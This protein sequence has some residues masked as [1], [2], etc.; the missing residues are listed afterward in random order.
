MLLCVVIA[1]VFVGVSGCDY[2][3]EVRWLWRVAC[4]RKCVVVCVWCVAFVVCL[5]FI[6]VGGCRLFVCVVLFGGGFACGISGVIRGCLCCV[7][8]MCCGCGMFC[9]WLLFVFADV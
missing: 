7:W 4:V 3:L 2:V 5:W 8:C 6:V 9:L 1:C